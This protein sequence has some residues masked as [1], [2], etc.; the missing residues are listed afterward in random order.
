M[1]CSEQRQAGEGPRDTW[2]LQVGG[3]IRSIGREERAKDTVL[4]PHP[5]QRVCDL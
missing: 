5:P 3:K 4:Y 2:E 1:G